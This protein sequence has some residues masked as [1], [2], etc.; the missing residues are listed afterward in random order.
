MTSFTI[1]LRRIT[2][3][4]QLNTNKKWSCPQ[5]QLLFCCLFFAEHFSKELH[6]PKPLDVILSASRSFSERGARKNQGAKAPQGSPNE[7]GWLTEENVTSCKKPQKFVTRSLRRYRSSVLL[8]YSLRKTST[9]KSQCDF[10]LRM[11]G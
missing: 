9:T 5:G 2:K 11:T 3:N 7:C 8:R 6:K 4:K 10:S 1:G